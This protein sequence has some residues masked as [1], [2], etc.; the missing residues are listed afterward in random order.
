MRRVSLLDETFD[1]CQA[2]TYDLL[3]VPHRTGIEVGVHDNLRKLYIGYIDFH[4]IVTDDTQWRDAFVALLKAYPWLAAHFHSIRIGWSAR[5]YTLL[6]KAFFVPEEAK[7]LLDRLS[8]M[9]DLDTLYFNRVT[10]EILLL[11][12]IPSELI[13]A[14]VR[15]FEHFMVLHQETTLLRLG[16]QFYRKTTN[17]LIHL[18]QEFATISLY[19]YGLLLHHTSFEVRTSSDV[20]YY[21]AAFASMVSKQG[22][23]PTYRIV[24]KGIVERE[25]LGGNTELSL[26]PSEV[27][28]LVH[29]YYAR[30]EHKLQPQTETFSYGIAAYR[31]VAVGLF[32]L[33]LGE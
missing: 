29:E 17:I 3:L 27:D 2:S 9:G 26:L 19:Q 24:G 32:S 4:Y 22:G 5:T 1:P 12:A 21:I 28:E 30:N 10:E 20:L 15:I 18:A 14:L 8:P 25:I 11:F 7:L 13:N 31:E 33:I 6:P 16:L 23:I